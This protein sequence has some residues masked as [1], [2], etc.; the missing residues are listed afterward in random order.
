MLAVRIARAYTGRP[1]LAKFEGSYH[2][3]YDDV[4]W[5]LAPSEQDAGP[6]D[7]PV[8]VPASAGLPP[9]FGRTLVLPFND[10]EATRR[11]LAEHE[12]SIAAVIVEPVANRMGLLPPAPGFLEGLQKLCRE[13]GLVLIFDEVIAFRVGFHGAQGLIGVTPDLT[14]LGKIIGGGFPVGAVVGRA[15]VMAVSEPYRAGRVAH[16]GTFNG[17][18]VTM[19]AGKATMENWT[20]E[21]ISAL[22]ATAEQLRTTCERSAPASRCASP[23]RD[24]CSRSPPPRRS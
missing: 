15:D 8:A 20:P 18:P 21:V 9:G 12:G 13:Q 24:L 14:T 1:I 19:A 3:S 23:A 16:Y 11:L 2:G 7:R 5:S 4:S 6:V 17:N 10:L 22:N